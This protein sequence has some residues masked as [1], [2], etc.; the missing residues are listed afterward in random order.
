MKIAPRDWPA[1]ACTLSDFHKSNNFPGN[2]GQKS[3]P[4]NRPGVNLLTER[5]LTQEEIF[6][7]GGT[8]QVLT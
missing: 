4:G 2:T 8:N 6:A 7:Q 1:G 5:I 3:R